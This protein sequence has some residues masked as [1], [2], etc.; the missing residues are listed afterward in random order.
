MNTFVPLIFHV[1]WSVFVAFVERLCEFVPASGSVIANA[2][3]RSPRPIPRSQCSFCSRLPCRASTLPAIAGETTSRSK[4]VP[5]RASS[6]PTA[7]SS[8]IPRPP[9]S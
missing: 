7:A 1:P 6:S 3:L 9:P 2:I 5:A 4:G 8:V